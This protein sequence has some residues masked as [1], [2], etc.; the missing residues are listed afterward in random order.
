MARSIP[1]FD[2]GHGQWRCQCNCV[3]SEWQNS[4]RWIV[5]DLRWR[6]TQSHRASVRRWIAR[7]DFYHRQRGCRLRRADHR[8]ASGFAER[9][10]SGRRPFRQHRRHDARWYR[11]VLQQRRTRSEFQSATQ[12]CGIGVGDGTVT[13]WPPRAG[14]RIHRSAGDIDQSY[15]AQDPA[16]RRNPIA[17]RERQRHR[18]HVAARRQLTRAGFTA[19]AQVFVS[20]KRWARRRRHHRHDAGHRRWWADQHID[21]DSDRQLFLPHRDRVRAR[22]IKFRYCLATGDSKQR[23]S[24][25]H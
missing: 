7:F 14:W 3:A 13:G 18:I 6:G 24:D 20:S 15:R 9:G 4:D 5:H 25:C 2:R 1:A 22:C 12:Q 23:A 11:P 19:G 8:E 10:N 16:G 21:A 17:E